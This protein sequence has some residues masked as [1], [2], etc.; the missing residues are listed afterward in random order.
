[1]PKPQAGVFSAISFSRENFLALLE[2]FG[3]AWEVARSRF[4]F[5]LIMA[6]L[7]AASVLHRHTGSIPCSAY[8][9]MRKTRKSG[10]YT[11]HSPSY[12]T[13]IGSQPA[14]R[15]RH[16]SNPFRRRQPCFE[17]P[18]AAGSTIWEISTKPAMPGPRSFTSCDASIFTS[19][20]HVSA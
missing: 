7:L 19:G 4:L 14:L 15:A 8:C 11:I 17:I 5:A 18:L 3:Q 16:R 12:S 9:L 13:R 2:R 10:K 1:M 6:L 20:A